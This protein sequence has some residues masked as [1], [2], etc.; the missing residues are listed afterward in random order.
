MFYYCDTL[1]EQ[2]A[3]RWIVAPG[4]ALLERGGFRETQKKNIPRRAQKKVGSG[5]LAGEPA[6]R[7][8]PAGAPRGH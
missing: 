6:A 2:R 1:S 8:A 3:A 7:L 5:L 4:V